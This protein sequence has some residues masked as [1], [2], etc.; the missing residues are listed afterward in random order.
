MI[1]IIHLPELLLLGIGPGVGQVLLSFEPR[2]HP[3]RP[4]GFFF[5]LFFGLFFL[6]VVLGFELRDSWLLRKHSTTWDIP[7]FY[8][9]DRLLLTL[10][11]L[12][13]N[14]W[15]SCLCL[16]STLDDGITSVHHNAW[17]HFFF[18][19]FFWCVLGFELSLKITRCEL[20][21][22]SHSTSLHSFF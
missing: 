21:H 19:F 8:F 18:F 22:L 14:S 20:Y 7:C 10:P 11:E 16:S 2:L 13:S 6:V 17:Q 5:F 3:L 4:L 12:G 15:S 1:S 9:W